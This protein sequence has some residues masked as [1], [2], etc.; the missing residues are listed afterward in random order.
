MIYLSCYFINLSKVHPGTF[1]CAFVISGR[2]VAWT[3]CI[4]RSCAF[5]RGP[6]QG[7]LARRLL[8]PYVLPALLHGWQLPISGIFLFCGVRRPT[9]W[10]LGKL[11]RGPFC[12][13]GFPFWFSMFDVS[14]ESLNFSADLMTVST[15]YGLSVPSDPLGGICSYL[16]ISVFIRSFLAVV[17]WY[18]HPLVPCVK[19]D[20]KLSE[21]LICNCDWCPRKYSPCLLVLLLC[22]EEGLSRLYSLLSEGI[23]C[24]AVFT[25]I[26]QRRIELNRVD[27]KTLLLM[28]FRFLVTHLPSRVVI[29]KSAIRV[30]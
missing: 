13:L 20:P 9:P 11:S 14:E 8:P 21:V 7:W 3:V 24:V 6:S 19:G 18:S 22:D 15:W 25:L 17:F 23:S 2:R 12:S 30:S 28:I 10:P 16:W 4:I 26:L 5:Q 27:F 1:N 29:F